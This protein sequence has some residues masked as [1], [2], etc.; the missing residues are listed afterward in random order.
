MVSFQIGAI[1]C[2][3][4]DADEDDED[5]VGASVCWGDPVAASGGGTSGNSGSTSGSSQWRSG[6]GVGGLKSKE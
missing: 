4:S 5:N 2:K 1:N 6:K 3:Q